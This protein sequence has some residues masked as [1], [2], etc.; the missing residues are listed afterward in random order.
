VANPNKILQHVDLIPGVRLGQKTEG[1]SNAKARP[2]FREPLSLHKC[3][4]PRS[5]SDISPQHEQKHLL[6]NRSNCR[7]RNRTQIARP[8]LGV[9]PAGAIA[10]G[11]ECHC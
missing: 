9:G 6:H 7:Y 11:E 2:I 5:C 8:F 10:T 1:E 4:P 3:W